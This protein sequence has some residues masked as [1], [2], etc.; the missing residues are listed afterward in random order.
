MIDENSTAS[1]QNDIPVAV[2]SNSDK[3]APAIPP[4]IEAVQTFNETTVSKKYQCTIMP[5]TG[6]IET[7]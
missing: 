3:S 2:S 4:A 5:K 6:L 1:R 7:T